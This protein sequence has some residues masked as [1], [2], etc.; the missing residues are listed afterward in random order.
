MALSPEAPPGLLA[1]VFL[2]EDARA[3]ETLESGLAV[4]RDG[5]GFDASRGVVFR[6]GQA[7]EA[8]LLEARAELEDALWP[9]TGSS[10]RPP[11]RR[12]RDRRHQR[13]RRGCR[14]REGDRRRAARRDPP[15]LAAVERAEHDAAAARDRALLDAERA[16]ARA[17][18][19]AAE[20]DDVRRAAADA[21]REGASL[22]EER[23]EAEARATEAEAGH[24][25]LEEQRHEEAARLATLRAERAALKER[26]DRASEDARRARAAA[27]TAATSAR[28]ARARA[29]R[30]ASLSAFEPGFAGQLDACLLAGSAA[31][32]PARAAL[33]AFEQR[34]RDL[35]A[36]LAACRTEES[37]AERGL[38]GVGERAT[39]LEVEGAHVEERLNDARR[40]SRE[41]AERHGLAPLEATAPLPA[42]EAA[43]L[44]ARLERLE[45]RRAELGAV[46]P[47]ARQEY[48]EQLQ[49]AEDVAE[50]R[51]DLEAS[52]R[53]LDTVIAE[54]SQT[55]R[56][57]FAATYTQVEEG[58]ADVVQTLFPGG[59]GRAAAGRGGRRGRG[60][61]RA[62]RAG[63]RAR[64][65]ARRQADRQPRAAV[66]RRE[67]AR[68]ARV[69]V[70][71]VPG[72][73]VAVLRARRGRRAARRREH[74]ALPGAA[75][76]LPRR[77]PVHRHHA[78]EADDGGRRRAVRRDDGRR[79]DLA[80]AVAQGAREHPARLRTD[81]LARF[82]RRLEAELLDV[83]GGRAGRG[84]PARCCTPRRT[85][86]AAR[87]GL[88]ASATTCS[89]PRR[90]ARPSA[91]TSAW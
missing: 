19:A 10:A 13:P 78:P 25:V 35:S 58:F 48:E 50:Q 9:A 56:E 26:A 67:G 74:R 68:R 24:R 86:P 43:V 41:V 36:A 72:P 21:E 34:A 29:A 44:A 57:R 76:A 4:T 51:A 2:V 52:L 42:D 33:D 87:P 75:R 85:T 61:G 11:S 37:D 38:R 65:A 83:R 39:A 14:D 40:R 55:I 70:R 71:P 81:R 16:L 89:R 45:R 5:L 64:G 62:R 66:R 77:G 88:D 84:E 79:R 73:A 8:A 54:L 18:S 60:G 49:R 32:T 12:G 53:E 91:R 23:A 28:R 3:F 80:R 22:R 17:R 90:P 7:G 30:L 6:S 46:N 27:D 59:R 15:Q 31:R 1:G 69:P 20:L 47:L 82:R 63:H